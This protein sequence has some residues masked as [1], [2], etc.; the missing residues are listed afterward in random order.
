M[1]VVPVPAVIH[2]GSV[3]L[4]PHPR[5][6]RVVFVLDGTRFDIV[7]WSDMTALQ[8]VREIAG[9]DRPRR[10]CQQGLCGKCESTVDGRAQRL[11]ITS[12]PDLQGLTIETPPPRPSVFSF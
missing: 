6:V 1:G 11:C 4:S 12:A 8:A 3:P 9:H 2:T 7:V 5:E 10:G